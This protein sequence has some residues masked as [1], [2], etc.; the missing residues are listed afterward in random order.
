MDNRLFLKTREDAL[1]LLSILFQYPVIGIPEA[2]DLL[3]KSYNSVHGLMEKF[4]EV[5]I[6]G[7]ITEQRRNKTYV[8][9]SYLEVLEKVY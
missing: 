1:R 9:R 8:F 6:L 5:G 4:E 3:Q 7:Q 2:S